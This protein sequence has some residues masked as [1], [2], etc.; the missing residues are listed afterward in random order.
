MKSRL[1]PNRLA[2]AELTGDRVEEFLAFQRD[3]G[4]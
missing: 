2:V 4:R 1:E 3:S